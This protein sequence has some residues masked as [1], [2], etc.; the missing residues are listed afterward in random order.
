MSQLLTLSR[1][2]DNEARLSLEDA[3]MTAIPDTCRE[4][5]LKTRPDG[6]P[7]ADNFEIVSVPLPIPADGEALVRNLYFLVSASLRM[8]ISKGAEDV[9]GVPCPA[10]REGETLAGEALGEIVTAPAG[11]GFSPGDWVLHFRGW[12]EYATVPV[13]QCRP[14]APGLPDPVA[15]LGHG[16]TAYAA[17]TR[18]AQIRAG[19]TVFISSA[20]GAIGSMAGQIARLLGAD[21]VIGSTSSREKAARL[22]SELGYDAAVFR[23][24]T[25]IVEQLLEAAP[26]GID[27][28]IDNVGGEQLAAA[29]ATARVGARVV[30]LG[31][32]SGQLA[33]RGPGRTA[34]VELDSIQLL[35]KKI[36]LRGYSADD[37]PQVHAEWISQFA[38]WL[39]AGSIRFPHEII[40][41]LD[42]A[43]HALVRVI[44]GEYFGT[45]V[46]KP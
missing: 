17:L 16:W 39:K 9:E 10:L 8:M 18:G 12:R 14:V 38:E 37:D 21:R 34:P 19:D 32:L 6:L 35:L 22:V 2:L 30:I 41:G 26:Q 3:P 46:V 7:S 29:I 11:S 28:F 23:G 43:P 40:T 4:V 1:A 5:R 33:T 13:A 31:A 45:V 36:T 25:P 42:Y 20:A 44:N 24:A 27:V 15:Y